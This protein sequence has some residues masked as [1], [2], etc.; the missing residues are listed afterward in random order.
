MDLSNP[1][2]FFSN[3]VKH[4]PDGDIYNA[5]VDQ[6]H[7]W[8]Q[9]QATEREDGFC[10]PSD[11]DDANSSSPSD[12]ASSHD[13]A[14]QWGNILHQQQGAAAEDA[15][16]DIQELCRSLNGPIRLWNQSVEEAKKDRRF[17]RMEDQA[18]RNIGMDAGDATVWDYLSGD[19]DVVL[20]E[21]KGVGNRT[22]D[23]LV[24][25]NV[26]DTAILQAPPA[27]RKRPIDD[28]DLQV[29]DPRK[30][31]PRSLATGAV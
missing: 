26:V 28:I 5:G 19:D 15:Q 17:G 23:S 24:H 31:V 16:I 27:S 11:G 4:F 12:A 29:K 6:D 30:H 14:E 18:F 13:I 2:H 21:R 25:A 9:A 10:N 22:A 3:P 7:E 1:E 20:V 8:F